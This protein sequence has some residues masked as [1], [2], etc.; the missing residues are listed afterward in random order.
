MPPDLP[1]LGICVNLLTM[2]REHIA[3]QIYGN[4]RFEP[5]DRQKKLIESLSEFLASG[6]E[7]DIFIINGYAGTGK[8]TIIAALVGMLRPAEIDFVLMAPT[9]RA[10]KVMGRYAA[11]SAFTIHKKIYRERKAGSGHFDLNHNKAHDTVYIVDEASMLTYGGGTDFGGAVFGSGDL[12]EDMLDYIRMGRN[13]RIIIVGDSAQLPPVGYD[14]SPALSPEYM[15]AYGRVIYNTLDEV[16]RQQQDSGILHDATIVRELIEDGCVDF[17]RF[18]RDAFRD[19]RPIGGGELIEELETCYSR[20]GQSEVAVITRSNKRANHYNQGIRRAVLYREEELD[21]GDV[22]MVVKNNYHWVERDPDAKMAF[23]AN[24]DTARVRRIVRTRERYG[25]RF[26]W[27]ELV[28]GDYDDYTMECWIILDT[29]YSESPALTRDQS[30]AL[31]RSVELDYAHIAQKNKRYKA[32]LEDEFYCALQVKFA[33]AATCHKAQ[34]GQ[35]SAIFVDSMIF[36]SEEMTIDLLRWLYTAITRATERL[37][38]VNFD[39]RFFG[40]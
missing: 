12:I 18:A 32:V 16:V 1:A 13:N 20:Y 3:T 17:P 10:A 11:T 38:L 7:E 22:L 15:G 23:I 4:F 21:P 24:G 2:L 9:G 29:L 28:F 14:Y 33:Y 27:A 39:E 8:T 36:G 19:V 31:F 40:E 37:Y 34:G 25:F 6:S 5:T 35:W 30:E 26:A